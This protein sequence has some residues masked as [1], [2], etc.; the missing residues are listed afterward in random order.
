MSDQLIT[1]P[2][3][4]IKPSPDNPRKHVGDVKELAASLRGQGILVP[5]LVVAQGDHYLLVAGSR[6]L[7]A[8]K[9]I[10]LTEV[11][12]IVKTME[13]KQ[14]L[15]VMLV[16]NLHRE[17]LTEI[18]EAETY[19]KLLTEIGYSQRELAEKV[20][21][22]Q[23][24]IS[25]RISLLNLIPDV[26]KAVDEGKV[27]VTDALELVKL[28]E[29]KDAKVVLAEVERTPYQSVA[30]VVE[31]ANEAR[32]IL[33]KTEEVKAKAKAD[34]VAFVEREEVIHGTGKPRIVGKDA[35]FGGA[36]TWVDAK[37][38]EKEPCH[39]VS[40]D[41]DGSPLEVCTEPKNHPAPKTRGEART[42]PQST[43]RKEEELKLRQARKAREEFIASAVKGRTAAQP[44]NDAIYWSTVQFANSDPA[45]F[46]CKVLGLDGKKD[47]K[48]TLVAFA[49]SGPDN[50]A[51]AAL[52]V[53]LGEME[54]AFNSAWDHAA[55]GQY[56]K[57]MRELG[58]KPSAVENSKAK[59]KQRSA[60]RAA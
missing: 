57:T 39:A 42:N 32:E 46:A 20:G 18:E 56:L 53:A 27:A 11:P 16:E 6:R 60:S 35:H 44:R 49:S 4:K 7:Q 36:L 48:Q 3:T 43:A 52:S 29:P 24:H 37:A 12:V 51:R 41:R 55:M 19:A 17:D 8:A 10:G 25:K 23:S 59:V 14:R 58:Y 40:V 30:R 22:S 34:K 1:V 5:L 50:L 28:K 2:V 47:A 21:K 33:T 38:H 26:R 54:G 45:K 31:R 9:D 15:E 13:D